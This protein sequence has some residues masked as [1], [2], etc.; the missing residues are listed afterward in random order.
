MATWQENP[1]DLEDRRSLAKLVRSAECS[2]E[3]GAEGGEGG[4]RVRQLK[5]YQM[6]ETRLFGLGAASSEKREQYAQIVYCRA[7]GQEHGFSS[8]YLLKSQLQRPRAAKGRGKGAGK[9][10]K[11]KGRG[12]GM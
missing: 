2:A 9:G 4:A 11:G 10:A 12:K 1:A 5:G 3:G 6:Q 8:G 7:S